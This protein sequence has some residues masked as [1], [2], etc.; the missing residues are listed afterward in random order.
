MAESEDELLEQA[1][2]GSDEALSQLFKRHGP[3]VRARIAHGIS[4]RWASVLTTEDVMQESYIDAFLDIGGFE[5]HG[6]GAFRRWLTAIAENN[7]RNAI[8]G[9]EAQKRGGNRH[10]LEP[11]NLD[12][13]SIDL[14]ELLGVTLSTPSRKAAVGEACA[15]LEKAIGQL[16]EDYQRVVRLYDLEGCPTEEVAEALNRRHGAV[17]ML[18]ARAHRALRQLMGSDSKFFSSSA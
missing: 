16:P 4:P 7:L 5:P 12:K 3:T 2:S 8:E 18:R 17:F 9:L 1:S 6:S 13:S 11:R 10:R 15:V 14:C